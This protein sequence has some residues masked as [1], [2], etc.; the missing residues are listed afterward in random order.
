MVIMALPTKHA[1]K[2]HNQEIEEILF[3]SYVW[4]SSVFVNDGKFE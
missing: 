2:R 3:N 4:S 1:I